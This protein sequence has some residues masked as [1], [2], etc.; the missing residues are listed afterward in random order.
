MSSLTARSPPES[1]PGSP[2]PVTHVPVQPEA[3]QVEHCVSDPDPSNPAS[4]VSN[5]SPTETLEQM[6][7]HISPDIT[8]LV[9]TNNPEMMLLTRT[10]RAPTDLPSEPQVGPTT[11][12]QDHRNDPSLECTL[13]VVTEKEGEP[14][15][16]ALPIQS[17]Q[18]ASPSLSTTLGSIA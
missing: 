3:N 14:W 13:H 2:V 1:R 12:S 6:H 5:A 17:A 9:P 10:S 8:T 15:H 18:T 7:S 4:D 16:V 11:T